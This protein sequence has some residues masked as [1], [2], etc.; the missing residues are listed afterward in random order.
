M[1]TEVDISPLPIEQINEIFKVIDVESPS[2][3]LITWNSF[4]DTL[5]NTD[6]L[7]HDSSKDLSD[8]TEIT[9]T[10]SDYDHLFVIFVIFISLIMDHVMTSSSFCEM[11]FVIIYLLI[12][13]SPK[14]R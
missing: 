8:Y 12:L 10:N 14:L 6:N 4:N 2:D 9:Q 7:S 11:S 1:S 3:D 5:A 13:L